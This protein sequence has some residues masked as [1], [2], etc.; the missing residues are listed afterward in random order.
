[1]FPLTSCGA[2]CRSAGIGHNS[3]ASLKL[4]DEGRYPASATSI[5]RFTRNLVYR[6]RLSIPGTFRK[7][8]V[9]QCFALCSFILSECRESNPGLTNPN[10]EYYLCTTLRF[11]GV[12]RLELPSLAAYAPEAYAYTNSATRPSIQDARN[13]NTDG[14]VFPYF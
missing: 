5:S 2:R 11:V 10:R 1:M 3:S 12:G 6:F 9:A 8:I 13:H 7:I 14:Y 4:R